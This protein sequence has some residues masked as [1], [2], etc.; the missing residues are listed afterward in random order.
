MSI[1]ERKLRKLIRSLIVENIFKSEIYDY[2]DGS[3]NFLNGE[4]DLFTNIQSYIKHDIEDSCHTEIVSLKW[5]TPGNIKPLVMFIF[6]CSPV[7]VGKT[8]GLDNRLRDVTLKVTSY[9]MTKGEL[10][11]GGD[12]DP[13]LDDYQ[14]R[15]K[16]RSVRRNN[17][18]SCQEFHFECTDGIT[19]DFK[20]RVYR[21][22]N[23]QDKSRIVLEFV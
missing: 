23:S 22:E 12:S 9:P 14:I 11:I 4:G 16:L 17:E 18:F 1:S 10:G 6:A 7:E 3:I 15:N 2:L 20:I 8:M 19:S 13:G 21:E 5:K